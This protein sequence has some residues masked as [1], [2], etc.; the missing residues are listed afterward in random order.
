MIS[1]P[2]G[3]VIMEKTKIE[4]NLDEFPKELHPFLK[5]AKVYDSSSSSNAKVIYS[6]LGYYIKVAAKGRLQEESALTKVF[7]DRG[8]GVEVAVFLSA[9]KDYLVTKSAKG[10]DCLAYLDDPERLCKVLADT[11]RELHSRPIEGAPMSPRVQDY[12]DI[13]EGRRECQYEQYVL[14]DKFPINSKEEAWQVIQENK[15]R[16]KWDTLIHGD[17]CLPN[18]MLD[19]WKFSTFIDFNLAGVGDK[20]IDIYW[21]LWSLKYNLKTDKYTDLFLDLYGRENFE[22]DMLRLIAA[23][24][25]WG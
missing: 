13:A 24:E 9:D 23:F 3:E 18:V 2:Y 5:G 16:L 11:M 6:D 19:D 14:M 8:L 10:E 17:F 4:V 22:P 15:H 25:V 1:V 12:L 20:H 7:A 21:V